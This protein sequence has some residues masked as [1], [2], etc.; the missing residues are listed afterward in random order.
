MYLLY[1]RFSLTIIYCI[2]LLKAQPSFISI[3]IE[4]L[5]KKKLWDGLSFASS[6]ISS[7]TSFYLIHC[8]IWGVHR[9]TSHFGA[10]YFLTIVDDYTRYTWVHVMSFKSKTQGILQSFISWVETQFNCCVKTLRLIMALSFS[11]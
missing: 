9:I 6:L 7:H 8:D 10:C 3:Y 1:N 11:L 2:N 4:Y 5:L